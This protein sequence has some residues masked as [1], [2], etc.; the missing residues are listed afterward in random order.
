MGIVLEGCQFCSDGS[1][2]TRSSND[3]G[4]HWLTC[5]WCSGKVGPMNTAEACEQ[6][7]NRLSMLA[8]KEAERRAVLR[9]AESLCAVPHSSACE[10]GSV[11]MQLDALLAKC[12]DCASMGATVAQRKA[13]AALRE[14]F[15]RAVRGDF[16]RAKKPDVVRLVFERFA[17]TLV[18]ASREKWDGLSASEIAWAGWSNS[19]SMRDEALAD[20]RAAFD[21]WW[22]TPGEEPPKRP[23]DDR[24]RFTLWSLAWNERAGRAG[25]RMC[26]NEDAAPVSEEGHCA[27][28]AS[29][30]GCDC[31]Q[32]CE[33]WV[34]AN[35]DPE[36]R[37]TAEHATSVDDL[38]FTQTTDA[39]RWAEAFE[40]IVLAKGVRVDVD[41]MLAW[42]ANAIERGRDAGRAQSAGADGGA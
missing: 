21:S 13:R 24:G 38:A 3:A 25:D 22:V 28:R 36:V 33:R 4:E 10:A 17:G 35:P 8:T 34:Q 27:A 14:L 20:E 1:L 40:R 7:W 42:F 26:A 2:P 30:E 5:S 19:A 32:A 29:G 41:L 9:S 23:E 18:A 37:T 15:D 31:G 12:G 16:A 11:V 6:E 39:L